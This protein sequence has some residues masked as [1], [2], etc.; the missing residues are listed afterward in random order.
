MFEEKTHQK[1]NLEFPRDRSSR[2]L[3]NK[4]KNNNN[5][6]AD[7]NTTKTIGPSQ[8]EQKS[9]TRIEKNQKD[10]KNDKA[11]EKPCWLGR[12]EM[13]NDDGMWST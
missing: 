10:G 1:E 5:N 7:W 3:Q 9:A 6:M 4:T 13:Y 8:T 2:A 11:L 12:F